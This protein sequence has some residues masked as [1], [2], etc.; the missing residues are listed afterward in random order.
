M[1]RIARVA[2]AFC[3]AASLCACGGGAGTMVLQPVQQAEEKPTFNVQAAFNNSITD[4]T[5]LSFKVEGMANGTAYTG[6]GTMEQSMLHTVSEFDAQGGALRKVTPVKMT[7]NVAGKAMQ[8]ESA[9]QDYYTRQ[10]LRLLGRAGT[11]PTHEFTQVTRYEALPAEA[12]VGHSGTLY[13]AKRYSDESRRSETGNTVATYTVEPD[14]SLDTALL[15]LR[16]ADNRAD[17]SAGTVTTTVFRISQAGTAR[18]VSETT[19]DAVT[20]ST[21]KATYS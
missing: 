4:T 9:A 11:G 5:P 21:L 16:V 3:F 7:L 14:T 15:V 10:E 1:D 20:Q 13:T 2:L 12:Q 8:V 17:G 18:R 6:T 19:V